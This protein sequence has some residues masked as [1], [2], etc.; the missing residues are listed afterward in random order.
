MF[1]SPKKK[2][3]SDVFE[4]PCIVVTTS[5]MLSGGPIIT[6]LKRFVGDENS[7]LCLVGYQVEGTRGRKLLDQENE[8]EINEVKYPVKINVKQIQF[9]AHSDRN[10]LIHFIQKIN[11]NKKLEK[12]FL[13]HGEEEKMINFK[14][15]L[16]K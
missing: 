1:K 15:Y 8:M 11:N 12:V 10:D 9:S 14:Q 13:V 16:K 3:R 2:D 6:Y 4:Q 5:G 7:T